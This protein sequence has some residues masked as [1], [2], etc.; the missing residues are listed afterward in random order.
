M[1]KI[2]GLLLVSLVMICLIITGCSQSPS[3][4]TQT[5]TSKP[6]PA[7][8]T[9][10]ATSAPASSS[11][12][13]AATSGGAI[14]I[15]HIRAL[16]GGMAQTGNLMI[17]SFD[18][19][20][21]QVNYQVAGKQIQIITGDSQGSSQTAV[22]VAKKMVQNDKVAM[23]VG[24]NNSSEILAVAGYL[25]QVGIPQILST[26]APTN[27]LQNNQWTFGING[28]QPQIPAT[29]AA[30]A[31]D[32]LGFKNINI[33][34]T[35]NASGHAFMSYFMTPYKAKGGNIV[36]EKYTVNPCP[37]F[38][39]YMSTLTKA[40]AVVGWTSGADAIKYL[41]Q[42][43]QLGIDKTMPVMGGYHG[44]FLSPDVLAALPPDCA[45]ALIG[46]Y[47]TT[48]Y[49]PLLDTPANK[50]FLPVMQAEVGFIPDDSE[51]GPYQ[52]AIVVMEALKATGGDTTPDKLRQALFTV[53]PEGPMGP[54][55]FDQKAMSS[56]MNIYVCKIAKQGK[57]YVWQP[58]ETYKNVAPTGG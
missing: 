42:Y 50:Q 6:A 53:T 18:L 43:H 4:P 55:K 9:T 15:G 10:A 13:P 58:V 46:D 57:D 44:S 49:S 29:M 3:T 33:L 27:Q 56:Y 14:K 17:K 25:N 11:A 22:D 32:K 28:N 34:A 36:Q 24:P 21:K 12:S 45:D 40:D 16:T 30:Y 52:A 1:K 19:P 38:G 23:I 26:T 7:Q 54:Y 2:F 31:Y 20:F 39:P 37:D 48:P 5:Q 35:D 41:T 47:V 8:S 51:A